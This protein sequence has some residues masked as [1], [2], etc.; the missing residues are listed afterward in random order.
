MWAAG[1]SKFGEAAFDQDQL[2]TA[3][4]AAKEKP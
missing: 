3:A 4:N 2:Q 1:R